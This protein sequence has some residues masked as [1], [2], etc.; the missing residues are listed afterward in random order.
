MT[1]RRLCLL[2]ML[3][4]SVAAACKPRAE[5]R[6]ASADGGVRSLDAVLGS[7]D[8]QAEQVMAQQQVEYVAVVQ[9]SH[10]D[11]PM[12]TEGLALAGEQTQQQGQTTQTQGSQDQGAQAQQG[13]QAQDKP[14]QS[15]GVNPV[16]SIDELEKQVAEL[17]AAFK[18]AIS[19]PPEKID[20]AA[21]GKITEDLAALEAALQ[22]AR[23]VEADR[24]AKLTDEQ[25]ARAQA[26]IDKLAATAGL[27]QQNGAW[28]Q[29]PCP[30][31]TYSFKYSVLTLSKL[32]LDVP[33]KV[34]IS[35]TLD[36][37]KK[38]C[39]KL[40]AIEPNS[41]TALTFNF[42]FEAFSSSTKEKG[43]RVVANQVAS[44][45]Y[46]VAFD[47]GRKWT[48]ESAIEHAN[49]HMGNAFIAYA[50]ELQ[51]RA[52]QEAKAEAER[53]FRNSCQGCDKEV[54]CT[55]SMAKER[56]TGGSYEWMDYCWR[57]WPDPKAN[58]TNN[59]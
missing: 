16:P 41:A 53:R 43:S 8:A 36:Y 54:C 33:A 26:V 30:A 55:R 52:Q 17:K 35:A 57:R 34:G 24:I 12:P 27:F 2:V 20:V 44:D 50:N 40:T 21:V 23:T 11:Q 58:Y 38:A 18:S 48:V 47:S 19:A 15:Q 32:A 14:M 1:F 31:G 46:L 22:N 51:R 28:Y 25:K 39:P 37:W 6:V 59:Y 9:P 56:C 5:S 4:S 7:L 42:F 29:K 3:S 49:Y 13:D 45:T 10:F